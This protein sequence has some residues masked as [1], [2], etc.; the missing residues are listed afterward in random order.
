MLTIGL[1]GYGAIGR[2][3]QAIVAGS[4][5]CKLAAI[6]TR[7][8]VQDAAG[9]PVVHALEQL[10]GLQ[11][12]VVIECAGQA[13]LRSYAVGVL[14]SG[15]DLVVAS[16]GA[17]VEDGLR[18]DVVGAAARGGSVVRIP[19]GA[20]VGIDGLAAARL[21]GLD[22]V[23]YCGTMPPHALKNFESAAPIESST[24]V[25]DGTAR[26]AVS[27]FPKNAN[28]TGT[29]ALAGLGFDATRVQLVLDPQATANVH[30]L[31]A[32]GA[33]GSFHVKVCGNRISES[34]PSSRIVPGS[35]VQAALGSG[36]SRLVPQPGDEP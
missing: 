24:L 12:N 27:R 25:F 15:S 34:S 8:P 16:V 28:L 4:T 1:I 33:F 11:C 3:V 26:E 30:E 9:V 20:M 35:L 23:T 10:L 6:L 21:V 7:S 18:R 22:T 32:S 36:F 19:S 17:L 14:E 2:S 5:H 29:I 13:A 31:T